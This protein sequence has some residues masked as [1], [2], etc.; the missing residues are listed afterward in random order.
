VGPKGTYAQP[1]YPTPYAQ[2]DLNALVAPAPASSRPKQAKKGM[3]GVVLLFLLGAGVV[4][5]L[6]LR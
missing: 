1:I 3:T 4:V 2:F 6:L 5:Y